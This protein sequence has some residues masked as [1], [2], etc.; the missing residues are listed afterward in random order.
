MPCIGR[1]LNISVHLVNHMYNSSA[2]NFKDL[3]TYYVKDAYENSMQQHELVF[4]LF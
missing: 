3:I 2:D 4:K 1:L